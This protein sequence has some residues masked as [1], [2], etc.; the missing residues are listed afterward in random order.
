M[1]GCWRW[2]CGVMLQPTARATPTSL[3]SPPR[4]LMLS[5]ACQPA[6]RS[7]DS[8]NQV[9]QPE[10]M[11]LSTKGSLGKLASGAQRRAGRDLVSTCQG[12]QGVPSDKVSSLSE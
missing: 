4:W 3:A 2:L 9:G 6:Y 8:I 1:D 12:R 10:I 7:S 5:P 11:R